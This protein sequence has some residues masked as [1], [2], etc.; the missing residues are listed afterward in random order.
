MTNS[1]R[2]RWQANWTLAGHTALHAPSGVVIDLDTG[3]AD[4]PEPWRAKHGP[5]NVPAMLR[6]LQAEAAAIHATLLRGEPA[7][8]ARLT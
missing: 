8:N 2:Y 1:T 7:R 3:Q 4:A 5:H 6:R